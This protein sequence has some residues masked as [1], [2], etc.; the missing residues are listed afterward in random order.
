VTVLKTRTAQAT[1][2]QMEH[3]LAPE[4][5]LPEELQRMVQIQAGHLNFLAMQNFTIFPYRKAQGI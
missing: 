1:A 4:G 3:E 5:E 2:H